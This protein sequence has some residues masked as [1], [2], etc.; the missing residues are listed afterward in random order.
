MPVTGGV[1]LEGRDHPHAPS[2][3]VHAYLQKVGA[4]AGMGQLE[5]SRLIQ[6]PR[7]EGICRGNSTTAG[8]PVVAGGRPDALTCRAGAHELFDSRRQA[9]PNT[10]RRARPASCEKQKR[11]I[12]ILLFVARTLRWAWAVG[13]ALPRDEVGRVGKA[14]DVHDTLPD[15]VL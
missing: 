9:W 2:Q 12:L 4:G 5:K 10:E 11:K 15:T 3:E 8:L 1:G 13:E 6:P 7:R 14:L